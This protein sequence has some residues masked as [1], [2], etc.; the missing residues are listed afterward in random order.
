MGTLLQLLK[1][2]TVKLEDWQLLGIDGNSYTGL[3]EFL[4]WE[5][6][7]SIGNLMQKEQTSQKFRA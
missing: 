4:D 2:K 6:D 1:N 3:K 5:K 7:L